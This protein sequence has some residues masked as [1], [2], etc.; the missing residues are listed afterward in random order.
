MSKACSVYGTSRRI[1]APQISRSCQL[2]KLSTYNKSFIYPLFM[3]N[4]RS[5]TISRFNPSKSIFLRAITFRAS[6][7]SLRG[8]A[9]SGSDD[10]RCGY[11]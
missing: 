8:S 5:E 11:A 7:L 4:K 1:I 3:C 10:R 9:I 2:T 6:P